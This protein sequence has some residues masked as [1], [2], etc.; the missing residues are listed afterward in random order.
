MGVTCDSI[1]AGALAL[2]ALAWLGGPAAAEATA[3]AANAEMASAPPAATAPAE[4]SPAAAP[5][6][7]PDAAATP[8]GAAA[9]AVDPQMAAAV[10]AA[11]DALVA[12]DVKASPVGAGDWRAARL[13]IRIFYAARGFAPVWLDGHGLNPQGQ[14]VLRRLERADE[15]GLDLAAFP[16]PK[17][18]PADATPERLAE[19]E[20][21]LSAAVVAYAMQAS[22]SRIVPTRISSLIT[23]RPTLADPGAALAAVAAAADPDGALAGY[24]PQQKGYRDLRD[25]LSRTRAAAPPPPP[26]P[27]AAP[28]TIRIP[29][30][31]SLGLGMQDTRVPL[32]RA[33]L[34]VSADGSAADV[35]DLPVAAAVQAFQRANGLPPNGALTPATAAALSGGVATPASAPTATVSPA[36]RLS[37]LVANMEMWR[38][39]PRDMGAERIEINIPDYTLRMMEGDDLVHQARVIVGKPDTPTPVFSN[40][41]KYILVNPIWRVP[42]SI[43]RKELA[44]HLAEDPDYFAH[45]GYQVAEIGGHMFVSQPPGEGNA[46]GHILFMFPNEH[47][48]YLHDTPLR[49]LFGTARRAYSHGCVRLDQPM[50]LA[51]LV[52]G[53][54]W[55][56]RLQAM[57]GSTERTVM[58][59]HAIPIHL[60]YF[61]E[62]VDATGALQEREDV[63]GIAARVAG[64]IAK[65]SQD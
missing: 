63:Y 48:V 42:D 5:A 1:R 32:V 2:V 9:P 20:T 40:A 49:G 61:T 38:W 7:A 47:A 35:Y 23:A 60:E 25:Q 46:L 31:P 11:L 44:P 10:S 18:L 55:S 59:P 15:D 64:T 56:A 30:G 21:T 58:L 50:R 41:M 6:P 12:A 52:M 26:T 16:L 13:A 28:T 3:A 51:E 19:A 34:G 37:M 29:D 14:G 54:G 45:R 27:S 22:G 36:R 43:V 17:D 62:F 24:N 57:I 65:T 33:R 4:T 8:A 39:E 53:A